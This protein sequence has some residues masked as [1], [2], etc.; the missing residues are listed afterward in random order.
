VVLAADNSGR[1]TGIEVVVLVPGTFRLTGTASHRGAPVADAAVDV[2]NGSLAVMSARTDERGMYRLFG[3]VGA[4]EIRASKEG[5]LDQ[6]NRLTVNADS[7]SDF[8]LAAGP[9]PRVDGTYGLTITAAADCRTEGYLAL[10]G[11]ARTRMYSATLRQNDEHLEIDLSGA[12][13]VKHSFAGEAAGTHVT[14]ALRGVAMPN[15]YYYFDDVETSA[16]L[17][18]RLSAAELFEAVGHVEATV[19]PNAIAG[20]LKGLLA[21]VHG[22]P[23][24]RQPEGLCLSAHSFVLVRRP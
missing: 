12:D 15:F 20:T 11:T 22:S 14:F 6:V 7:T 17:V 2:L 19:S 24:L 9:A 4:V 18:E 13:M 3:V 21:V 8:E 1:R 23:P 5:Y 10:P 16:D